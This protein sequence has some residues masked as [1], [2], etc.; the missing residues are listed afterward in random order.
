M[1]PSIHDSGRVTLSLEVYE[2]GKLHNLLQYS[3]IVDGFFSLQKADN[4][5]L[6]NSV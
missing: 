6:L 5:I 2:E 3:V 4:Y 1:H